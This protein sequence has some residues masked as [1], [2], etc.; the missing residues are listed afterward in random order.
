M[1]KVISKESNFTITIF[2]ETNLTT[3]HTIVVITNK[4]YVTFVTQAVETE[5]FNPLT[6]NINMNN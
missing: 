1:I 3:S 5:Y 4:T 6:H 2:P